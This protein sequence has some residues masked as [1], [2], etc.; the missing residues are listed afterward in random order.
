MLAHHIELSDI[1]LG[2]HC[3]GTFHLGLK[4]P[5]SRDGKFFFFFS[6]ICQKSPKVLTL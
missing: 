2:M 3:P 1:I 5:A 4:I 6:Q